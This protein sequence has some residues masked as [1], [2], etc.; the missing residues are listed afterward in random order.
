VEEFF[1]TGQVNSI[2]FCLFFTESYPIFVKDVKTFFMSNSI[3]DT[4]EIIQMIKSLEAKVNGL[5]QDKQDGEDVSF[6]REDI[7]EYYEEVYDEYK[8]TLKRISN[9][10]KDTFK[11]K[12]DPQLAII[13]QKIKKI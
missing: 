1:Q 2:I 9:S 7:K 3:I 13:K 11:E 6:E 10:G 4:E 12:Y 5:L 8:E